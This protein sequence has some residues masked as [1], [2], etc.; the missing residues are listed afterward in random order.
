MSSDHSVWGLKRGQ[1]WSQGPACVPGVVGPE[2][3]WGRQ[4]QVWGAWKAALEVQALRHQA[5]PRPR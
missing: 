3:E 5:H 1:C 4:T 2:P